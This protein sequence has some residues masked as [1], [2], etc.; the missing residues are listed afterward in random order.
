MAQTCDILLTHLID[1]ITSTNLELVTNITDPKFQNKFACV[2]PDFTYDFYYETLKTKWELHINNFINTINGETSLIFKLLFLTKLGYF[3]KDKSNIDAEAIQRFEIM[4]NDIIETSRNIKGFAVKFGKEINEFSEH[5]KYIKESNDVY[6]KKHYII[7]WILSPGFLKLYNG[8]KEFNIEKIPKFE[9]LNDLNPSIFDSKEIDSTGDKWRLKIMGNDIGSK[10]NMVD[11][12]KD[13]LESTIK[14]NRISKFN[15]N[16]DIIKVMQ[17]LTKIFQNHCLLQSIDIFSLFVMK[18]SDKIIKTE[19]PIHDELNNAYE[20]IFGNISDAPISL[21]SDENVKEIIGGE[22]DS[23]PT[24]ATTSTTTTTTTTQSIPA[25]YGKP[26]V[27]IGNIPTVEKFKSELY[28]P[29]TTFIESIMVEITK[30]LSGIYSFNKD[31]LIT[32]IDSKISALIPEKFKSLQDFFGGLIIKYYSELHLVIWAQIFKYICTGL[33]TSLPIN[34]HELTRFLA[35]KVLFN[36]GPFI[37]KL[38]QMMNPFLELEQK[39]EFGLEKLSYPVLTKDEVNVLFSTAVKDYKKYKILANIS[40]SVGHVC[41][42]EN[43]ETQ[44]VLIIKFIKPLSIVQSCVEYKI[45]TEIKKECGKNCKVNNCEHNFVVNML[46]A[47]GKELNA[48]SETINIGNANVYISNYDIISKGSNNNVRLDVVKVVKNVIIDNCW[49][50][51]AMSNAPGVTLKSLVEQKDKLGNSILNKDT[52]FRAKLHRSLDI[53]LYKFQ[54]VV[55]TKSLFHNDLHTGNIFYSYQQSVLTLID[56]GGVGNINLVNAKDDKDTNEFFYTLNFG[57]EAYLYEYVFSYMTSFINKKC[58]D[59]AQID[60][61]TEHYKNFVNFLNHA[62]LFNITQDDNI[63]KYKKEYENAFMFNK[64]RVSEETKI[65]TKIGG[66]KSIYDE[67]KRGDRS[68]NITDNDV[69]LVIKPPTQIKYYTRNDIFGLIMLF[70]GNNG[71]N[72]PVAL[73]DIYEF[74]KANTLLQGSLKEV[75]Y[76]PIRYEIVMGKFTNGLLETFLNPS[77]WLSAY[78]AVSEGGRGLSNEVTNKITLIVKDIK[79]NIPKMEKLHDDVYDFKLNTDIQDFVNNFVSDSENPLKF[80]EL[81]LTDIKANLVPTN[82]ISKK[83]GNI[84]QK[85]YKLIK[86]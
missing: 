72:L 12:F 21:E 86:K 18:Y 41:I 64:D 24:T 40:A 33:F 74:L 65:T 17:D 34:K 83:G 13:T 7:A 35:Q 38:L 52:K 60:I 31:K 20:I 1:A 58:P 76:D 78:K 69:E 10:N 23:I 37:L 79:S 3:I 43:T 62:T 59:S 29:Q 32:Q 73:G 25:T 67:M 61:N 42:V 84:T 81:I 11:M 63:K 6:V 39:K 5:L 19:M 16:K 48:L 54:E 30:I 26:I 44:E 49:Y 9:Y 22:G 66:E 80:D 82:N 4:A 57:L 47:N 75:N 55:V 45:L 36:S 71:I 70:Y 85:K 77:N 46:D 68:N 51:L 53:L 28:N 14:M 27:T 15:M 50:A 56:F 8:L 2:R